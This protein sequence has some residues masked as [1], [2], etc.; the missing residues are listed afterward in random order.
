MMKLF[1]KKLTLT[2]ITLGLM[3]VLT[4]Q[5]NAFTFPDIKMQ[6]LIVGGDSKANVSSMVDENSDLMK[7]FG[8]ALANVLSSQNMLSEAFGIKNEKAITDA[9]LDALRTGK[10]DSNALEKAVAMT[11]ENQQQI[12]ESILKGEELSASGKLK[13]QEAMLPYALGTKDAIML[14]PEISEFATEVGSTVSNLASNP[15]MLLTL[16][17]ATENLAFVLSNLPNLASSWSEST[18]MLLNYGKEYKID[19]SKAM[20]VEY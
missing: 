7:R 20:D 1:L 10:S 9:E 12:N 19:V 16:V 2:V 13:Y 8:S 17:N 18:Q 3:I 11:N 6:S 14:V 4:Q 15:M 5:A